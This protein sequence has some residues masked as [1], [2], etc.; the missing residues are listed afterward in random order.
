MATRK[1]GAS[2]WPWLGIAALVILLDQIT[3]VLIVGKLQL[4]D[5]HPITSFFNIV[6]W[7]NPGY[8]APIPGVTHMPEGEPVDD[9]NFPVLWRRE[10]SAA[11]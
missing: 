11:A 4:G 6:R 10:I 1:S 3:K 2:L 5:S 7:H 8:K 9:E